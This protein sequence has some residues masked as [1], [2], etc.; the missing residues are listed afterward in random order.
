MHSFAILVW[1]KT[2]IKMYNHFTAA[3]A[4]TGFIGPAHVEGLKR[5]GVR[6]K[7]ILGSNSGKIGEGQDC[8]RPGKGLRIL[9][10]DHRRSGKLT[11]ST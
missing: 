4:G 7:G 1:F 9:R 2:T 5:L 10:R 3:V 8:P 11:P 6:V